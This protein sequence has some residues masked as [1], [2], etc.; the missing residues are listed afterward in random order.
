LLL[1]Y[2]KYAFLGIFI[3]AAVIS[4][5]TDMMSQVVMAVPMLAS[6]SSAS[7]SRSSSRSAASR[8]PTDEMRR[9][10]LV[11]TLV[12]LAA[13]GT[14]RTAPATPSPAIATNRPPVVRARCE[15][16]TVAFGKV[17]NV[18]VEALDPDRDTLTYSWRAPAGSLASPA[19]AQTAWTA[20]S[21]EGPVFLTIRVEDGKGGT[22]SD[23][24]TI[25]VT[26]R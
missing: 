15:P 20:P 17:A 2:F 23:V 18:R 16:C 7:P 5:G 21:I 13:C 12:A 26:N 4:P 6:T 9:T 25:T 11:L 8:S 1:K 19:A 10:A 24:I 3:V 14:R 22:A